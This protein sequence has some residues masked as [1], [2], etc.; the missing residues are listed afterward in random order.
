MNDLAAA[1]QADESVGRSLRNREARP[2]TEPEKK[3]CTAA[4]RRSGRVRAPAAPADLEER[5]PPSSEDLAGARTEL[6]IRSPGS[7]PGTEG[8]PAEHDMHGRPFDWQ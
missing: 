1:R 2:A 5:L 7:L 3:R 6:L 8:S 4:L